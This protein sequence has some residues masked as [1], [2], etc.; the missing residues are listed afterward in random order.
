MTA[1]RFQTGGRHQTSPASLRGFDLSD[2]GETSI[3]IIIMQMLTLIVFI[4]IV[5]KTIAV[6]RL[7]HGGL[8]ASIVSDE[9]ESV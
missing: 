2:M 5:S 9:L 3:W 7:C 1:L 8:P 4:I 6:L